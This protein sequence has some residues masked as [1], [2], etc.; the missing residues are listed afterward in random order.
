MEASKPMAELSRFFRNP[1]H[2]NE[3]APFLI[4]GFC[5]LISSPML[6]ARR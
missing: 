6:S 1:R 5:S 4:L 3:Q 2:A